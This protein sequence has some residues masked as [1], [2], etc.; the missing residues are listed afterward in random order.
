[1]VVAALG[2]TRAGDET[3]VPRADDTKLHG[4]SLKSPANQAPA[5]AA[6]GLPTAFGG[7]TLIRRRP[8]VPTKVP[9]TGQRVKPVFLHGRPRRGLTQRAVSASRGLS[10]DVGDTEPQTRESARCDHV[11]RHEP[12]VRPVPTECRTRVDVDGLLAHVDE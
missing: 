9:T 12:A 4:T 11:A 6:R 10:E 1:H 2:E 3:D 7:R 5:G 8:G